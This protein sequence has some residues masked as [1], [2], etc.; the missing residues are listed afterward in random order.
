MS[1]DGELLER[2]VAGVLRELHGEVAAARPGESTV[3]T[4]PMEI[5]LTEKVITAELLEKTC[6]G[7]V[8]LVLGNGA[9]VTPS[10]R[11]FL[12]QHNVELCREIETGSHGG[13]AKSAAAANWKVIVVHTTKPLIGALDDAARL[14]G[15]A[16]QRA[17][18]GCDVDAAERATSAL[19]RGEAD[20]AVVFTSR[21]EVVACRA[22]RNANVRGAAVENTARIRAAQKHLSA[23]LFCIDATEKTRIELRNLL[24]AATANGP[25]AAPRGWRE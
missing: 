8:R 2:I 18:A 22:N 3:P 5:V 16:W 11:D 4:V 21:P 17:L 19:C 10:G 15:I 25:P 14:P 9:V 20:G 6:R 1:V 12:R 23:N 24:R 13:G 7:A